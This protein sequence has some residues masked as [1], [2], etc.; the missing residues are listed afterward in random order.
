MRRSSVKRAVKYSFA[1]ALVINGLQALLFGFVAAA[2]G[3]VWRQTLALAAAGP[4]VFV[5]LGCCGF[6]CPRRGEG[7]LAVGAS[8]V[9]GIAW[10]PVF[11]FGLSLTGK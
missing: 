4:T 1:L 6:A 8:I 2:S 3:G 10:L 9:M 7:K 5:L 11:L